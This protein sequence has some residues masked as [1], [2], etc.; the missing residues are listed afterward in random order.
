MVVPV[1]YAVGALKPLP[2]RKVF[3]KGKQ[4]L[5]D[6]LDFGDTMLVTTHMD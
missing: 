6:A 5:I 2:D 1:L 3:L 4:T